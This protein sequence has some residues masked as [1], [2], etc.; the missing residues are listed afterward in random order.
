MGLLISRFFWR[1]NGSQW[2]FLWSN[3]FF[4]R[5]LLCL[6]FLWF[7]SK[8][9]SEADCTRGSSYQWIDRFS[10]WINHFHIWNMFACKGT[11]LVVRQPVK[12][13][14]TK[15]IFPSVQWIGGFSRWI[16]HFRMNYWSLSDACRHIMHVME[17]SRLLFRELKIISSLFLNFIFSFSVTFTDCSD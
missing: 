13:V 7:S 1:A 2:S 14:S 5:P 3:I 10:W 16:N 15:M 8:G 6:R 12:K 9:S 17:E 11:T 4:L